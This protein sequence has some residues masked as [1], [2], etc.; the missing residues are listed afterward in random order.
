MLKGLRRRF[1][2]WRRRQFGDQLALEADPSIEPEI[3]AVLR[4][5]FDVQYYRDSYADVA[6]APVDPFS[7][8]IEHGR[9]EH[10]SPSPLIEPEWYL[11]RYRDVADAGV[12][13][14]LHYLMFGGFEGRD[15]IPAGFSSSW[16]FAEYLDA[17]ES[18]LNPL[19]HF[20]TM[21]AASG[22][23]PSP[24]FDLEWYV[25]QYSDVAES[26]MNPLVHYLLH[27]R[28]EGR[29]PNRFGMSL[30]A[31]EASA[32][33]NERTVSHLLA[34]RAPD[35]T[36][37][38]IT[39]GPSMRRINVVT[40]SIG[41]ESL[42]GGTATALALAVLWAN[43]SDVR[44]RIV[45][46]HLAPDAVGLGSLLATLGIDAPK[47]LEFAYVPTGP[48]DYL[49]VGEA[50]VFI[51][52]SWWTTASVLESIPSDRVVYILQEDERAFYPIGV[53]SLG[54]LSIMNRSDIRV[55]VNTKMLLDALVATGVPNLVK[56]GIFF[57][58][59]FKSFVREGRVLKSDGPRD[60]FFYARPQNPRNLFDIGLAAIDSA[61]EEG[62][63]DGW[64]IHL[65]GRMLPSMTFC[66]GSRPFLHQTLDWK[67]Y[68]ELI[69]DMD[70]GL[71]LMA[72]PHP[73]YPPLDLAAGGSVVVT[74]SWPGKVDLAAISNRIIQVEPT[75]VDIR[76]GII[77]AIELADEIATV[78]FRPSPTP[79]F[80]AWSTNF[81]G[82]LD[83]LEDTYAD[84]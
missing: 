12:D 66:D 74:N 8:Y 72:S 68:R 77:R 33:A 27:G 55:L 26:G 39:P 80:E 13:P 65:A 5:L 63:L 69:G 9:T 71:S 1:A 23:S 64:R 60:F 34:E 7:H 11:S 45:T 4:T 31:D 78:A 54:A 73:S 50:E 42:F 43:R 70:V 25:M 16:Y 56:T 20:I 17:R 29:R 48:G 10:R 61:I 59:S 28:A 47:Q 51:T 53:N 49:E 36:P 58:P 37:L 67:E 79:Y 19:V 18:G 32:T 38:R 6:E 41:P 40:D 75:A 15:P 83:V 46:R 57:E 62:T 35:I 76:N 22:H 2:A 3:E 14:V 30:D 81:A 52:T 82:V 84:V 21:G 44:L 24:T